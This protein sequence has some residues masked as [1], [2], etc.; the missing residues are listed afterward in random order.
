MTCARYTIT[1]DVA[2]GGRQAEIGGTMRTGSDRD[3]DIR[4]LAGGCALRFGDGTLIVEDDRW[5]WRAS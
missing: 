3:S 2:H 4:A 1:H 5:F